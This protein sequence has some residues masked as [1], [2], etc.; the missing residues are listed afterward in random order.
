MNEKGLIYEGFI[1]SGM[2]DGLGRIILSHFDKEDMEISIYEGEW[3]NGEPVDK[4]S[5]MRK[6][7]IMFDRS[8]W[9]K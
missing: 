2:P 3:K 9:L 4:T 8:L 1:K 5:R 7:E 6:G